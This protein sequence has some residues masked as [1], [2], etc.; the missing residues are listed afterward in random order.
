MLVSRNNCSTRV[1]GATLSLGE[2]KKQNKNI[3][4]QR[5]GYMLVLTS[6]QIME[7]WGSVA[8]YL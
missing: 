8:G 2:S 7:L 1:R 4:Q 6:A 3:H 5:A